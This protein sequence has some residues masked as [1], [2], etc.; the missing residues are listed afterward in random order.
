MGQECSSFFLS[1]LCHSMNE[2]SS[3]YFVF[4]QHSF[5]SMYCSLNAKYDCS[6]TIQTCRILNRFDVNVVNQ[7]NSCYSQSDPRHGTI[8][9][10]SNIFEEKATP[11]PSKPIVVKGLRNCL[12]FDWHPVTRALYLS[13]NGRDNTVNDRGG[14][15]NQPDCDIHL[16]E[17]IPLA[18]GIP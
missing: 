2:V 18:S 6:S 10:Y 17:D 11:H 13:N 8:L 7:D 12:G 9:A 16:V 4:R 1:S 15:D 3:A 14:P 5:F